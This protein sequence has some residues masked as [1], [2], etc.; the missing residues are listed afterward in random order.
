MTDDVINPTGGGKVVTDV[1]VFSVSD[2]VINPTGG[3]K[4]VT[5]VVVFSV[6][7]DVINP[8]GGRGGANRGGK[9]VADVGVVPN[10]GGDW[11]GHY[12]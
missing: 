8:T 1:V 9:V 5:D 6:S 10:P 7:D 4:V 11:R 12:H 2:D 3:G